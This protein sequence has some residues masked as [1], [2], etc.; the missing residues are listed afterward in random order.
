MRRHT[1]M[2]DG[3]RPAQTTMANR[4]RRLEHGYRLAQ[5]PMVRRHRRR[6]LT[7]M[8]ML[9]DRRPI[10]GDRAQRPIAMRHRLRR[11]HPPMEMRPATTT[12]GL[13]PRGKKD[14]LLLSKGKRQEFVAPEA[15][16]PWQ[17]NSRTGKRGRA[18]PSGAGST[19]LISP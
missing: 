5:R 12:R 17:T 13:R 16:D 6:P 2:Q 1:L 7:L 9:D 19:E 3:P 14:R 4:D 15:A 18:G 10:T 11:V 8:P